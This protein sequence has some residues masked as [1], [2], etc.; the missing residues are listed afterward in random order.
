MKVIVF[1]GVLMAAEAGSE[2]LSL[3][4]LARGREDLPI[5]GA[6]GASDGFAD[7]PCA[8]KLSLTSF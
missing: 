3:S 1:Q 7:I 6:F 8:P 5:F 4:P 2:Y